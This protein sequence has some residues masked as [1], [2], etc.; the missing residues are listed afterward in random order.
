MSVK[1][2]LL[3]KINDELAKQDCAWTL[4]KTLVLLQGGEL[5]DVYE[6]DA[7]GLLEELTALE[8]LK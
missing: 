6:D 7:A 8:E 2:K 5:R 1:E 3:N 4:A